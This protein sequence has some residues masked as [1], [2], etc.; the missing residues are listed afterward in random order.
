M[1]S[2]PPTTAGGSVQS[3]SQSSAKSQFQTCRKHATLTRFPSMGPPEWE[4]SRGLLRG[5]LRR[6]LTLLLLLLA[7]SLEF[8]QQLFWRLDLLLLWLLLLGWLRLGCP[9]LFGGHILYR[10]TFSAL[11]H[12]SLLALF[13]LFVVFRW[14][15][16]LV[17]RRA[18]TSGRS[19]TMWAQNNR[20]HV[21]RI[22]QAADQDEVVPRAIEK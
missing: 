9:H 21:G 8:L 13:L 20:P 17:V 18:D 6:L 1:N 22:F 2:G 3:R 11:I 16:G 4:L 5:L 10:S 19:C 12:R 14:P 15:V 7:E